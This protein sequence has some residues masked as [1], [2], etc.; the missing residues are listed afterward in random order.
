[1]FISI[2]H[3]LQY[4]SPNQELR[5]ASFIATEL[6]TKYAAK[7]NVDKNLFNKII[8]YYDK[9][10]N[11]SNYQDIKFIKYIIDGFKL[12][13]IL[14][15]DKNSEKLLKIKEQIVLLEN[16]IIYELNSNHITAVVN[17]EDADNLNINL[18][19]IPDQPDKRGITL[20]KNNYI[21]CMK[22]M[23]SEFNRKQLELLYSTKSIYVIDNIAKL[24]ILRYKHA[25]ILG[26]E[27]HTMYK[28][29]DNVLSGSDNIKK[30]LVNFYNMTE[31]KYEKEM[32]I[33]EKYKKNI[34]SWDICYYTNIWKTEYGVNQSYLRQFFPLKHVMKTILIIFQKLMKITIQ[35]TENNNVWHKTVE[36]FEVKEKNKIIGYFFLD[37][38]DRSGKTKNIK[39]FLIQPKCIY[40]SSTNH[41]QLPISAIVASFNNMKNKITLLEHHEVVSLFH[42]FGLMMGH[43][44]CNNKY[45]TNNN[46]DFNE[47][48]AQIF[49]YF[50]WDKNTIK[51]LSSHY[52]TKEQLD[53][54]TIDK[55]IKTKHLDIAINFRKYILI[56]LFDQLIH[57]SNTFINHLSDIMN[58]NNLSDTDRKDK[59]C[60]KIANSYKQ[61][62]TEIF[63]TSK[64]TGVIGFNDGMLFPGMWINYIIGV[65]AEYYNTIL[66]IVYAADIYYKYKDDINKLGDVI[67]KK[68]FSKCV[69]D[70]QD[71]IVDILGRE[72]NINNFCKLH[73]FEIGSNEFSY[74]L[75][76]DVINNNP[77]NEVYTGGC[78][79]N[80]QFDNNEEDSD[81]ATCTNN[82]SEIDPN[83]LVS[84]NSKINN[85]IKF[86]STD[87]SEKKKNYTDIFVN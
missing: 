55:M 3:F 87:L 41:E 59:I 63:R 58:D 68:I 79:D 50:C 52:K 54:N 27:N 32:N 48:P 35:K 13:G 39:C 2:S 11:K 74:Y 82:F 62:H 73:G 8:L 69:Y 22:K 9:I 37:L 57:S 49:E 66:S 36:Y 21:Y 77:E 81:S 1:M 17:K 83:T 72:P 84:I 71:I 44:F 64:N 38:Y 28:T 14:L 16:K 25:N 61:L 24:I 51:L 53:D 30:F 6:L 15:N 31:L 43:L 47:T 7:I 45:V 46:Y 78:S 34:N 75:N 10:K 4:T 20:T 33:L 12:N 42:E 80:G 65:D 76:T 86:I 85:N 5:E 67:K 29:K 23:S 19:M 56:A 70:F 18:K 26:Y 40:P 60:I